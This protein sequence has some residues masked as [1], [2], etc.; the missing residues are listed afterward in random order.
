[1]NNN[2]INYQYITH[3]EYLYIPFNKKE[4][5]IKKNYIHN[6]FLVTYITRNSNK[7]ARYEKY[8]FYH[9]NMHS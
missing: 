5:R 7:R 1:M 9:L 4:N 8:L 6:K 2:V 3:V